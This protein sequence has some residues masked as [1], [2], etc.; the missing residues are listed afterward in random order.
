MPS[1]PPSQV[2]KS[3]RMCV[4]DCSPGA[5]KWIYTEEFMPYVVYVAP[6]P[7]EELRQLYKV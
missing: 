4:V 7:L 5:V 3:G 1:H 2:I 6:P